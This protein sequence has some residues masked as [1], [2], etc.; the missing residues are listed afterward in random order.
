MSAVAIIEHQRIAVTA[1]ATLVFVVHLWSGWR[2]CVKLAAARY[3]SGTVALAIGALVIL[4]FVAPVIGY[5]VLLLSLVSVSAVD[6]VQ[7]EHGRR[8]RVASLTPRPRV[9]GVPAIW[10]VVAA[11]SAAMVIPYIFEEGDRVAASIVGACTVV[12]AAIAWRIAK[13]TGAVGRLRSRGRAQSRP[14]VACSQN[15]R[16][17]DIGGRPRLRLREFC[18]S[19]V[20][21]RDAAR[22]HRQL[23]RIL[24]LSR[25]AR[26][27]DLVR[28]ASRSS[29]CEGVVSDLFLAVDPDLDAPPFQQI[30]DQ[31]RGFIER[32]DLRGGDALPTV[33]QL[34]ADLGVAPN[35]VARAYGELQEGRL[36]HRQRPA[37]NPSRSPHAGRATSERAR[38]RCGKP[39]IASWRP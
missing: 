10:T 5:A 8:R 16:D 35:T 15:R 23:S 14:G 22:G 1:T 37:R 32:G 19:N 12:M 20:R 36:A 3:I 30:V 29:A 25:L 28:F 26:L 2:G 13:R 39:S 33:R 24:H 17:V 38:A 7:E 4:G 31:L 21:H 6:L 27:G 9:D 34:A 11:L 18:K